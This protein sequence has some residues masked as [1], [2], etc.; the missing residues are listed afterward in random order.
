MIGVG[1]NYHAIFGTKIGYVGEKST[2][3]PY[4]TANCLPRML[5]LDLPRTARRLHDH[6]SKANKTNKTNKEQYKNSKNRTENVEKQVEHDAR[7][8]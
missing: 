6:T 2:C 7:I 4:Q 1:E 8:P 5:V 3:L